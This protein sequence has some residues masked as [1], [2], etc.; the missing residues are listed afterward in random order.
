M[1]SVGFCRSMNGLDGLSPD[2]NLVEMIE[3]ENHPY[4]IGC[5][6]HPELKSRITQPHPLFCQFCKGLLG[7]LLENSAKPSGIL[8]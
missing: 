5:Q 4:F 6:F 1:I 3:L 7:I 2:G 8:K